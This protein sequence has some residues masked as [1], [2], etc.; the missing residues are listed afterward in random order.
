MPRN[1]P[2]VT[3]SCRPS[4]PSLRGTDETLVGSVIRGRLRLLLGAKSGGGG[5]WT[6]WRSP[7]TRPSLPH[8]G[9]RHSLSWPPPL[10]R[11]VMAAE[12]ISTP[13]PTC[14]RFRFRPRRLTATSREEREWQQATTFFGKVLA[15]HQKFI[16]A[17]ESGGRQKLLPA[18]ALADVARFQYFA[19]GNRPQVWSLGRAC[20]SSFR[21]AVRD[22]PR[23]A[24]SD[25]EPAPDCFPGFA[26]PVEKIYPCLVSFLELDDG[27]TITAADGADDI[28]PAG[29]RQDGDRESGGIGS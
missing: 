29:W 6:L 25:Y 28:E 10:F 27:R 8:F 5:I 9:P 21:I 14:S 3:T 12:M 23:A 15:W 4:A 22:G 13:S 11:L 24:T 20:G 19:H 7:L 26:A 17:L 18:R 1:S 2:V 16:E